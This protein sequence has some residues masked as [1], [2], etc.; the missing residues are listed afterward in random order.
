VGW[1]AVRSAMAQ[2]GFR[3]IMF[4]FGLFRVAEMA[5]WLTLLVWA[6]GEGGTAAAGIIAVGQLVPAT[7]AAPL[8]STLTDRMPRLRALRLGYRLQAAAHLPTAV[9]CE[10]GRPRSGSTSR[11]TGPAAA[12]QLAACATVPVGSAVAVSSQVGRSGMPEEPA[13]SVRTART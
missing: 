2:P 4:A 8:A 11:H 7:L 12:G 9:V 13:A 6:Y 5:T 3:R 1:E 10:G